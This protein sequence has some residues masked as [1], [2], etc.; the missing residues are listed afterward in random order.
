MMQCANPSG[1]PLH[2]HHVGILDRRRATDNARRLPA[3]IRL[4]AG[5]GNGCALARE[6]NRSALVGEEDRRALAANANRLLLLL[7]SVV[8]G[9][10]RGRQWLGPRS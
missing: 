7:V 8:V 10:W 1:Y 9:V 6:G 4:P 5:E 3:P 2:I